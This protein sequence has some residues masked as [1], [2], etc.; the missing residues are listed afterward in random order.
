MPSCSQLRKCQTQASSAP[1]CSPPRQPPTS[2][3]PPANE[4]VTPQSSKVC[5]VTVSIIY[6]FTRL[7]FSA[8]LSNS[9][10]DWELAA[11][12]HSAGLR[13]NSLRRGGLMPGPG[14][15]ELTPCGSVWHRQGRE[16]WE[17]GGQGLGFSEG[18]QGW[19]A[20]P[21]P[22]TLLAELKLRA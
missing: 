12:R 1:S 14:E 15:V 4:S 20:P 21:H 10:I 7:Q 5:V 13:A 6:L 19:S 17:G 9:I 18:L 11:S 8:C 16:G 22:G 2:G 3:L